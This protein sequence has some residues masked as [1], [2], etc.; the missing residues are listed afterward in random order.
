[1][2]PPVPCDSSI[3]PSQE[4]E[5]CVRGGF[6]RVCVCGSPRLFPHRSCFTGFFAY[7]AVVPDSKSSDNK[8]FRRVNTQAALLEN[9][10]AMGFETAQLMRNCRSLAEMQTYFTEL[11]HQRADLAYDID[12]AVYKVRAKPPILE[13]LL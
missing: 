9:L 8:W 3:L 12:G 11:N 7:G 1:M 13:H 10:A 5:T 6:L 4:S 2:Q